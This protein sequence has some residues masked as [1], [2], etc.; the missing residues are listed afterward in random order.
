MANET[1]S[2]LSQATD[3]ITQI[4]R[5]IQ[6][7]PE[8]ELIIIINTILQ[9]ILQAIAQ[10]GT[11]LPKELQWCKNIPSP[12]TSDHTIN[13]TVGNTTHATA[14]NALQQLS[15]ADYATPDHLAVDNTTQHSVADDTIQEPTAVS[16]LKEAHPIKKSTPVQ[17]QERKDKYQVIEE[18]FIKQSKS[19]PCWMKNPESFWKSAEELNI[20]GE[21][22]ASRFRDFIQ[23]ALAL[24][25]DADV[26]KFQRR[27]NSIVAFRMFRYYMPKAHATQDST[28]KFLGLIGAVGDDID[29]CQEL[30]VGGRRRQEF[31]QRLSESNSETNYGPL[32]LKVKDKM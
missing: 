5:S 26:P 27:F 15:A 1:S 25:G 17:R 14:N 6:D 24:E 31:C 22:D 28:K 9:S 32:F 13:S 7:Y 23:H 19:F 30:L 16:S 18:E 21:K 4:I 8:N 10:L 2:T 20:K 11:K 12:P 3:T 29:S